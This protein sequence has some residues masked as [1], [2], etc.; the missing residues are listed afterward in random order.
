MSAVDRT[1]LQVT[2]AHIPAKWR[3][4]RHCDRAS[5]NQKFRHQQKRQK[6]LPFCASIHKKLHA[7]CEE[8]SQHSEKSSCSHLKFRAKCRLNAVKIPLVSLM[9]LLCVNLWYLIVFLIKTC[10][11]IRFIIFILANTRL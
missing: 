1:S 6:T 10:F 9:F 5:I 8:D 7:S 2:S 3:M 4:L 11:V